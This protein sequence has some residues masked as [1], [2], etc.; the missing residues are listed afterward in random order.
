[1]EFTV[2]RT[3]RRRGTRWT[4][5]GL[6][7][8][9]GSLAWA[10]ASVRTGFLVP[11]Y[12]VFGA[13]LAVRTGR[14]NLRKARQ[15]FRLRIDGFGITLHDAE[16]SWEQIGTVALSHAPARDSEST[17]PEPQ[18]MLWTRPGVALPREQE[19]S[20]FGGGPYALVDC[21]DLDQ[22]VLELTAALAEHG[23][24]RFETAPRE[25]R[26]PMPVTVAGPERSVAGGER[27]FTAHRRAGLWTAIWAVPAVVF[28]VAVVCIVYDVVFT[29]LLFMG[30]A[31]VGVIPCWVMAVRCFVRWRRPLRLRIGPTG[32]GMREVAESERHFAWSQIAAVS[33]GRPS[34]T[35][36]RRPW[37]MVWPLPGAHPYARPSQLVDGHRAYALVRLDRLPGGADAVLPVLRAYAGERYAETA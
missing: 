5:W 19:S 24:A 17:P 12:V 14:K 13:A 2:E 20:M 15:P 32:I 35:T 36:D 27:D 34:H 30:T 21:A 31:A 1:M 9:T 29:S 16:L 7:L 33:V 22:S 3:L 26:P 28:T 23:G 4:A 37:L 10:L 25:V 8:L 6:V 18:L 11:L